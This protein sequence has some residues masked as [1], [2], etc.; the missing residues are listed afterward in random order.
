MRFSGD[1]AKA[2][3][4]GA[5]TVMCGSLFAGTEEAPGDIVFVPE[6]AFTSWNEV[7]AQMLPTLQAVSG[8]LTPFVQIKYLS[9]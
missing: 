4:S 7:I 6:T 3:A 9:Q 1:I 5:N 2:V 8:L